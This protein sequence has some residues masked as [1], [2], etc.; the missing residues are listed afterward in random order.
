MS[1]SAM[2][3]TVSRYIQYL[4]RTE[5][6]TEHEMERLARTKIRFQNQ[7]AQVKEEILA[8]SPSKANGDVS[9]ANGTRKVP[10]VS[11]VDVEEVLRRA[12][13]QATAEVGAGDRSRAISSAETAA[14]A[15]VGAAVAAAAQAVMLPMGLVAM[16]PVTVSECVVMEDGDVQEEVMSIMELDTPRDDDET[17][18]TASGELP[19][20]QAPCG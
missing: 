7:L 17:T 9:M 19:S 2:I 16:R 6:E 11:P 5:W 12:A 18:T 8:G 10:L 15:S 4:K 20:H 1:S 3:I 14:A 13:A